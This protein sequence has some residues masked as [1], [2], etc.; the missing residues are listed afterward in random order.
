[1]KKSLHAVLVKKKICTSRADPL[2]HS[3]YHS[4]VARKTLLTQSIFH[5]PGSQKAPN[6]D[7]VVDAVGQYSQYRQCTLQF[8]N[9][10][11][12][13]H[14]CVA[15]ER[16]SS[17]AWL[18]KFEPSV[19]SPSGSDDVRVHGLSRFQEIH[20][21]HLF[22]ILEDSAH[23][24][25]PTECPLELFPLMGNSHVAIPWTAIWLHLIEATP[26]LV[27]SN[28]VKGCHFVLH[29]GI[30]WHTF[31]SYALLRQTPFC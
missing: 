29:G 23:I 19:Q 5:W 8:W 13:W 18:W 21:D 3:C 20:K 10:S 31:V 28:D 27:T 7:Y 12:A 17:L 14:S 25:I 9:C 24:T 2:R 4:I 30:Q 16:F 26:H 15:R 1:M 22:P 6:L 11:G